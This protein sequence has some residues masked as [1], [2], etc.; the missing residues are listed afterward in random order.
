MTVT[1]WGHKEYANTAA[2]ELKF[3]HETGFCLLPT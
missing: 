1:E 2:A 3:N